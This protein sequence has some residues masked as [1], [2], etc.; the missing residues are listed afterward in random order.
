MENNT[1]KTDP[2]YAG[3][4]E[5]SGVGGDYRITP[6]QKECKSELIIQD[7]LYI[8]LP[9]KINWFH[10]LMYRVFFGIKAQNIKE[11]K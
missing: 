10:R 1:I 6:Y 7:S 11:G 9:N 5:M 2:A 4:V 3:P 8:Y